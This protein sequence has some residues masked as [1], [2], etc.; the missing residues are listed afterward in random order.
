MAPKNCK[1]WNE[2]LILALRARE[3]MARQQG[4]Q[5]QFLWRDGAQVIEEQRNDIYI[6]R[7]SSSSIGSCLVSSRLAL[8]AIVLFYSVLEIDG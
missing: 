6:V 5:R 2:D 1:V 7:Y 3:E 8:S 4:K